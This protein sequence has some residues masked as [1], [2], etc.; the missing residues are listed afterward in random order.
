ML[1]TKKKFTASGQ[2]LCIGRWLTT[3]VAAPNMC[4]NGFHKKDAS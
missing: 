1:L 3:G 4:F 2:K